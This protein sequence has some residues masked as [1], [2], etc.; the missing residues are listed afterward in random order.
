[1][2][3]PYRHGIYDMRA[4]DAWTWRWPDL[5]LEVRVST[6]VAAIWA[7]HRQ[8]RWQKERG[9]Q[10]FA[11]GEPD[12]AVRLVLATP[13]HRDDRAGWTWLELDP[14]RCAHEIARENARGLRYVGT[15]HTHPQIVPH[16]SST[17]IAALSMSGRI[18]KNLLPSCLAVI[19]GNSGASNGVRAW[20]AD[21]RSCTEGQRQPPS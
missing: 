3:K 9:G 8:K 12:G 16:I 18:N 14:T 19:V 4:A 13:P 7:M 6:D 20:R 10:L 17:D 2:A 15:W 1:M 5:D 21:T 11:I